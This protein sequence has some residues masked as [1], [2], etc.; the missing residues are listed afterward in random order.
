MTPPSDEVGIAATAPRPQA[1]HGIEASIVVNEFGVE[2]EQ[3]LGAGEAA[4]LLRTRGPNRL[5]AAK[6]ESS[7]S[8]SKTEAPASPTPAKPS[9]SP[10]ER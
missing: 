9:A 10:P 3:G 5:T 7:E 6:K 4:G 8:T 2:P 1:W